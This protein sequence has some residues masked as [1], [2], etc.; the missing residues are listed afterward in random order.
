MHQER[1]YRARSVASDL[2]R[3]EVG[4]QETDLLIFAERDLKAEATA[5]VLKY[6]NQIEDYIIQD[7]EFQTILV[8]YPVSELAPQ[9]VKQ[10]AAAANQANVGPMAAIAGAIADFVALDLADNTRDLIIEN[11]G[12]IYIRTQKPRRILIYA[13][14]SPY[15][16]KVGIEI[17]PEQTPCGV[18]TSSGTVGHSLSFGKADAVTIVAKTATLADAVATAV[19]NII[20]EP[21]DINAGIAF[22]RNI[23]GITGV[24][25]IIKDKLGVW[26]DIQLW[27]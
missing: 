25:I 15:S 19:G 14:N 20:K 5:A 24:V 13:G 6:R 2:V 7:P 1:T 11:G 12:D 10:M 17:R 3:F 22:A 26:G 23:Q 21:T 16:E 18:C 9:I 8:P 4:I 27:K